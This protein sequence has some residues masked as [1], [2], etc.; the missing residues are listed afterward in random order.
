MPRILFFERG[1]TNRYQG[2][3]VQFFTGKNRDNIPKE[4]VHLFYSLGR[5]HGPSLIRDGKGPARMQ[6]IVPP[7]DYT[8]NPLFQRLGTWFIDCQSQDDLLKGLDPSTSNG[9]ENL[10]KKF[11]LPE[12]CTPDDYLRQLYDHLRG[13]QNFISEAASCGFDSSLRD[14]TPT[15]LDLKDTMMFGLESQC[16]CNIEIPEG[17]QLAVKLT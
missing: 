3:A 5:E 15:P 8:T 14:H 16:Y 7:F 11:G 12:D 2:A 1:G 17:L 6:K 9:L 10:R 13:T 4:D